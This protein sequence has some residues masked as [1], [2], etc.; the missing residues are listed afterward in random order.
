MPRVHDRKNK[1][2]Q[3]QLCFRE[4]EINC[5]ECPCTCPPT[6][7]HEEGCEIYTCSV[8]N[9]NEKCTAGHACTC[10]RQGEEVC[11]NIEC[12]ISKICDC[13]FPTPPTGEKQCAKCGYDGSDGWLLTDPIQ[14][15]RCFAQEKQDWEGLID[16][17][18]DNIDEGLAIKKDE[19]NRLGIY[20]SASNLGTRKIEIKSIIRKEKALSKEEGR[21]EG[22]EDG[23]ALRGKEWK[24]DIEE[25][26]LEVIAEVVE[27]ENNHPLPSVTTQFEL[28]RQQERMAFLASLKTNSK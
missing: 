24:Q 16:E 9:K 11:T 5:K 14:C 25:A 15:P 21:R 6:I 23:K 7:Q 28:K 19:S 18:V 22:Y 17:Q 27:W 26:R 8:I 20:T 12:V 13:V 4:H 3:I 10:S 1:E 2:C